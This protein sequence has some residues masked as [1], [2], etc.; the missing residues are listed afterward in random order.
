MVRSEIWS[1]SNS[2]STAIMRNT[3]F[4]AALDV[5]IFSDRETCS[6]PFF[7]R[8]VAIPSMSVVERAMREIE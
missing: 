3:I 7:L 1:R 4:S 5:S 8:P 2:A 6:A